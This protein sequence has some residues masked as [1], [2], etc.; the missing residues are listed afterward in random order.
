MNDMSKENTTS[1]I[2]IPKKLLRENVRAFLPPFAPIEI[3]GKENLTQVE[4][5]SHKGYGIVILW[6]HFSGGDFLPIIKELVLKYNFMKDKEI[7]LPMMA[8]SH[9]YLNAPFKPLTYSS[10]IKLYP[11]VNRDSIVLLR[12]KHRRQYRM[13]KTHLVA[14]PNLLK[15]LKE[16]QAGEHKELILKQRHLFHLYLDG[17]TNTLQKGGIVLIAPQTTRAEWLRMS[18][19]DKGKWSPTAITSLIAQLDR[20]KIDKVAFLPVGIGINNALNY[21]ERRVHGLNPLKRHFINVGQAYTKDELKQLGLSTGKKKIRRG[22][23]KVIIEELAKVV[24]TEYLKPPP[25]K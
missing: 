21:D 14:N 19:S 17:A 6:N 23:E 7:C 13:A 4:N 5:L 8:E 25:Q 16:K 22:V 20:R 1:K 10:Q 11:V 2:S 12:L 9:H 3:K 15:K 18:T 24:P